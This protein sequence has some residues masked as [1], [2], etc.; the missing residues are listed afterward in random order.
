MFRA[1][2]QTSENRPILRIE[3]KLA[4][5]CAEEI[6]ALFTKEAV[7]RGLIVDLTSVSYIGDIGE[8]LLKWL[9]RAGAA[10][11]PGNL[12]TSGVC[13]QLGLR[14]REEQSKAARAAR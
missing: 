3:G 6:M 5:H 10:F 11:A 13:E 2:M 8:E 1:V 7:P 12:Y 4:G 14:I 9:G